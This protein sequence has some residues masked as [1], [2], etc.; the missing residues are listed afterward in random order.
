LDF[1]ISHRFG[2]LNSGSYNLRG[3]V[4][5]T[6]HFSLEYG[7]TDWL[8]A[9]TGRGSFEKTYDG[10]LKLSPLRQSTGAMKMPVSV[11]FLSSIAVKTQK[12]EN[13]EQVN[14]FSSR[15][16][17]VYQVMI[18]RKFSNSFSAQVTPSLVHRNMT[19]TE[20]DPNDLYAMGLGGR[21]KLSARV[22]LNLEYYYMVKPI[23]DRLR[24]VTYNPVSVGFDIETGG[25]V[26]QLIF[27]N[28]LSM[29][30]KGFIGET[31]GRVEQG[32]IHFGF[33][34][35]RFFTIKDYHH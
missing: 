12:W 33:N 26:F 24:T 11:S 29:I 14:Y 5:S 2:R 20:L 35:S 18:G 34:I 7:I 21:I 17:Y 32:D 4:Q 3:L 30:E 6:I 8:M 9:G 31:T 1:R 22:S 28:S 16:S 19:A 27:T 15:L 10:F 13:T 25:H 23:P